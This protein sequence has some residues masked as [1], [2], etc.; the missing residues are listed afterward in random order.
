MNAETDT[1]SATQVVAAYYELI[2]GGAASFDPE[3]LRAILADNLAFEG[4]IAGS[5]VG[6]DGFVRG[7]AG[8][9]AAARGIEMVALVTGHDGAAA[10]YD[11]ELPGGPVRFA[12]FFQISG[13]KIQAL[14]LHYD[15]TEYRARGGR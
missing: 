9:A 12:E 5:R 8:F 3:R 6:A 11:A 14:T 2:Q 4:P 7:A 13:G 1:A 15:T 10:L